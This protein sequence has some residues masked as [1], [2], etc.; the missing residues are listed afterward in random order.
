MFEEISVITPSYNQSAFISRTVESVLSQANVSLEY[1]IF[2]GGST[3][4]TVA[5]LDAYR[6]R[7]HIVSQS[8]KGQA[9]AV[10]K[11]LLATSAPIIGWLNSDDIYYPGALEVVCAFFV[12]H[13]EVD[14]VYGS[15]NWINA[16]DGII[17]PYPT[18]EWNPEDLLQ[19]CFLCQ[20]AVFFRRSVL[21]RVG[22]L[23]ESLHYCM[24]YEYWV[25]CMQRGMIFA[26]VSAVLAGSR[27]HQ[28]TKTICGKWPAYLEKIHMFQRSIG[29][30]PER[31]LLAYPRYLFSKQGWQDHSIIFYATYPFLLIFTLCHFRQWPTVKLLMGFCKLLKRTFFLRNVYISLWIGCCRTLKALLP[32]KLLVFISPRL[33]KL[34][35][36]SPKPLKLPRTYVQLTQLRKN[37]A[38]PNIFIVTPSF[39]QASF[40]ERTLKSV[41]DQNYP[42]LK[43][44]IQDGG[45]SDNTPEL[46]KRY[47]SQLYFSESKKD[48]GQS[49]ALN[50][51]F[52]RGSGNIMAYLNSDDLLLPGSLHYVARYFQDHPEVDVVYGH[53]VLIDEHDQEIG[54]WIL[55]EHDEKVLTFADYIPQETLFWRKSIWDK[56][57]ACIDEQFCFAMDWDLLLRFQKAGARFKRLPRFLGAFRI[58]SHQKTSSIINKVGE[59]EMQLLRKR[60][61]ERPLSNSEIFQNIESYLKKSVMLYV[62]WWLG[63]IRY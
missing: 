33:G 12:R 63:L 6:D 56:V 61:H 23:D 4:G 36:Y 26:H 30:I 5:L 37:T 49:H 31:S 32:K 42:A 40:L 29:C 3:D 54:R 44:V 39:N 8:D 38:I 53:R 24:D 13:P 14:I 2:D 59:K 41:L 27:V 47:E 45:S 19:K 55:P 11:G 57:G 21:A 18:Q 35:Q 17:Q 50:L 1:V 9:H 25:R 16:D 10:N 7:A 34:H 62:F 46:I 28:D 60:C 58:H 15:A 43:Y 51:G 20:P 48:N 22:L 52:N